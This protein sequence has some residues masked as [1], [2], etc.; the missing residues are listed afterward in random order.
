MR[1]GPAW[2]QL[3]QEGSQPR[4]RG[5]PEGKPDGAGQRGQVLGDREAGEGDPGLG[6]DPLLICDVLTDYFF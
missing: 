5:P 1:R 4:D 3:G 6:S 2:R